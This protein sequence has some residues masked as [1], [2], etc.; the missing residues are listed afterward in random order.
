MHHRMTPNHFLKHRIFSVESKNN[1]IPAPQYCIVI[2][3]ITENIAELDHF[4]RIPAPLQIKISYGSGSYS[5]A[6]SVSRTV[7]IR[8]V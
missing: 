8:T 6:P 1:C 7:E 5:P 3:I 4:Y 2:T